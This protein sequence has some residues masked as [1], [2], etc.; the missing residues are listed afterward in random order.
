MGG[1]QAGDNGEVTDCG[2]DEEGDGEV[3]GP[4]QCG[5]RFDTG[6]E[7]ENGWSGRQMDRLPS[8]WTG[9][10]GDFDIGFGVGFGRFAQVTAVT[11]CEVVARQGHSSGTRNI[12]CFRGGQP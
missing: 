2:N 6:W 12:G 7:V 9:L 3:S 11:D 8:R 1:E 4:A 5:L 10:S